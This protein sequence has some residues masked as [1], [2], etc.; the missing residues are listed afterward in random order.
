M[1]L[2]DFRTSRYSKRKEIGIED[3]PEEL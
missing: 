1:V 2:F 3:L